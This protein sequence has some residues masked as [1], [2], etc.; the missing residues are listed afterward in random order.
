[1]KTKEK[2]IIKIL[3]NSSIER[4]WEFWTKPEH[5]IKWNYASEDWH[6]TKAENDLR[7]GGKFLTRMEAKD[8]SFGFDLEGIYDE[9]K[10]NEK[11]DYTLLDDRKV[12][13]YFLQSK[14]GVEIIQNFEAEKENSIELQKQ[15]WQAILNNFKAYAEKK[16]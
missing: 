1:M 5:I 11:L 9:I 14:D 7:V 8:G 6:T 15:G 2:I 12:L 10:D 16:F 4:V 3:I 13:I